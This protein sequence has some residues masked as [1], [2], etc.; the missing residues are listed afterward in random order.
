MNQSYE[1]FDLRIFRQDN[2]VY[3]V[4][5]QRS[6][7]GEA[8][9]EFRLPFSPQELQSMLEQLESGRA[10]REFLKQTGE[11]LYKLLFP[12][13]I[14]RR[15][16]ESLAS[17]AGDAGLR[18]RLRIDAPELTSLPWEFLFD[19]QENE[20]ISLS[21]RSP[22]VRYVS[23]GTIEALKTEAPVRL[24]LVL[25]NPAD[26]PPL[27]TQKEA[28]LVQQ[29][30]AEQIAQGMYIVEALEKPTLSRLA[31]KL[32]AGYQ[33]IHYLGHAYLDADNGRGY[34]ILENEEGNSFPVDAETLTPLLKDTSLRLMVLNACESGRSGGRD[35]QLGLAPSLVAGGVSA[36]V[37]TQFPIPDQTAILL[38][39]EFYAALADN[40]PVDAAVGEAR[41]IIRA[42]VGADQMDWGIPV[43][44]MRAPDGMLLE[45]TSPPKPLGERVFSKK[46]WA[47]ILSGVALLLLFLGTIAFSLA[48]QAGLIPT[49]EPT[50]VAAPA[51]QDEFLVVVADFYAKGAAQKLEVINRLAP[52]IQEQLQ[53]TGISNAR[54]ITVPNQPRDNKE[55]IQVA[56][57]YNASIIV[58]GWY[59]DL[60]FEA[61][62]EVLNSPFLESVGGAEKLVKQASQNLGE[63]DTA[64]ETLRTYL[65]EGLASRVNYLVLY[66]IGRVHLWQGYQHEASFEKAE[67]AA[68]YQQ[69]LKLFSQA[70]SVIRGTS[71]EDQKKLSAEVLYYS[72]GSTYLRLA[73]SNADVQ[74]MQQAVDSYQKAIELKTDYAEAHYDLGV[75]AYLTAN[76]PAEAKSQFEAAAQYDSNSDHLMSARAYANIAYINIYFDNDYALAETNFR[77]AYEFKPDDVFV[78]KNLGFFEYMLGKYDEAVKLTEEGLKYNPDEDVSVEAQ[79][80]CNLAVAYLAK[81]DTDQAARLYE[82]ALLKVKKLPSDE[83]L[84]VLSSTCLA[85]LNDLAKNKTDLQSAITPLAQKLEA[86]LQALALTPTPAP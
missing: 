75:I 59:D 3:P 66:I 50:L 72:L 64:P 71:L 31:D 7:A 22:L 63:I 16:R 13:P 65:R 14:E 45:V 54:L 1:L 32:R 48:R 85:D 11:Q 12:A 51:T 42:E 30:L 39:R 36:V 80:T 25:S 4:E 56:S 70:I 6:P 68:D 21:P 84:Q 74:A 34:L 27:D 33:I 18:V 67:A 10:D 76:T 82:D 86:A 53:N 5:V 38:S 2:G 62:V 81:G 43:L 20:F 8:A 17:L 44:F 37:A 24:L 79:L 61:N 58:W 47:A 41:K 77:K 28:S 73:Q 69:A 19:P 9:G 15:Y 60:G 55:A 52:S 49:P 29:A 46:T 23:A 83:A 26:M 57:R 40:A 35:A 78:V